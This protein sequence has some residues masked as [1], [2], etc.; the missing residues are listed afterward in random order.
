MRRPRHCY[1]RFVA[2]DCESGFDCAGSAT[3]R[4]RRG[5]PLCLFQP[6]LPVHC[7]ASCFDVVEEE[8]EE[9]RAAVP[10]AQFRLTTADITLDRRF[11]HAC[12]FCASPSGIGFG[13]F[14][15][16]PLLLFP[17][18]PLFCCADVVARREVV[19]G[20]WFLAQPQE[21]LKE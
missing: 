6:W 17:S 4:V 16:L 18:R 9:V 13:A 15:L 3:G 2:T 20:D 19:S 11:T 1:H 12:H 7:L 8:L 10:D 14:F 21:T 5:V